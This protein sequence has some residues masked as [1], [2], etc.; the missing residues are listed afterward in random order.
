MTLS[1]LTLKGVGFNGE[2]WFGIAPSSV[3][4]SSSGLSRAC[5]SEALKE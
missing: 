2:A 3:S 1:R 5:A 4:V